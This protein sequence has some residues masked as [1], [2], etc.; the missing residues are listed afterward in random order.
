MNASQVTLQSSKDATM[1]DELTY[2]MTDFQRQESIALLNNSNMP[3]SHYANTID[4]VIP[5][6]ASIGT[7][8]LQGSQGVESNVR[9]IGGRNI[10][11]S[12]YPCYEKPVYHV[13]ALNLN[14][15][16]VQRMNTIIGMN[17]SNDDDKLNN[18]N[19]N[20]NTNFTAKEMLQ[21]ITRNAAVAEKNGTK[22]IE[23]KLFKGRGLPSVKTQKKKL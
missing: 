1:T 4:A 7:R 9:S 13:G 22:C 18:I 20:I 17:N 15:L 16:R 5:L 19:K 11:L 10:G 12:W 6:D 3:Q 14:S 23:S 2:N 8:F 21:K